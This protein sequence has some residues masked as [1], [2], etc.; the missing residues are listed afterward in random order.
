[1]YSEPYQK[2]TGGFDYRVKRVVLPNEV[3]VI[4][5]FPELSLDL[6]AVFPGQMGE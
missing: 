4:P 6:S 3:V 2:Q 5:G 1:M